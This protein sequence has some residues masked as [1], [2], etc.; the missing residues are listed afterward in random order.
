MSRPRITSL[1]LVCVVVL[2]LTFQMIAGAKGGTTPPA[3]MTFANRTV[4][5]DGVL[6]LITSDALGSYT[7]AMDGVSCVVF[8]GASGDAHCDLSSSKNPIRVFNI[9][10]SGYIPGTGAGTGP[11]AAFSSNGTINIQ[12]LAQMSIGDT[13]LTTAVYATQ[14]GEFQFVQSLNP[15][16]SAVSA[17][18][19]DA[20]TW[21]VNTSDPGAGDVA[22]L[23]QPGRGNKTVN[24]GLYHL[25]FQ[26]TVT[27][28]NCVAP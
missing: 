17:T 10:P 24:A 5:T 13:K 9:D 1:C 7:N 11:R 16:T 23:I 4:A 26:I 3:T 22:Q 18:R 14:F 2:S 12:A 21:I 27:C 15:A 28:L 6:D 20:Q 19:Y 25:P 8:T